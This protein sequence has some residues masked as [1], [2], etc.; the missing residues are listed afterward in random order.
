MLFR[1]TKPA[2]NLQN[3]V[4]IQK[5]SEKAFEDVFM[6]PDRKGQSEGKTES[7]TVI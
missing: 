3:K 6:K 1:Q 4:R 5:E 7:E 2:T